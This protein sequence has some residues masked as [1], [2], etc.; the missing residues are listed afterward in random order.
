MLAVS[1]RGWQR[2]AVV[3]LLT[4]PYVLM[5]IPVALVLLI[6]VFLSEG[7]RRY[8]LQLV[9]VLVAWAKVITASTR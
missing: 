6:S 3:A 1:F 7:R 2:V 4:L 9:R 8:V 5:V